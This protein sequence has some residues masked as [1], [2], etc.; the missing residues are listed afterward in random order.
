[1][2]CLHNGTTV[3]YSRLGSGHSYGVMGG[4]PEHGI[5]STIH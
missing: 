1:M 3:L 5:D 2:G 4:V